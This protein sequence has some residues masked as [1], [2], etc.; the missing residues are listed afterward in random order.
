M[1]PATKEVISMA[2]VLERT[3]CGHDP[4][5]VCPECADELTEVCS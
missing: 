2:E 1:H 4:D 3:D 5:L